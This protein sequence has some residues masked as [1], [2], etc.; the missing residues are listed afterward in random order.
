MTAIGA[1]MRVGDSRNR[2]EVTNPDRADLQLPDMGGHGVAE[3]RPVVG[4][5][6]RRH[7]QQR[8]ARLALHKQLQDNP[9]QVGSAVPA[10]ALADVDRARRRRV[11][12]VVVAVDVEACRR[13]GARR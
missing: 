3:A 12:A 10:V 7:H 2:V 9:V 8:D 1:M 5:A 4:V 6:A 11:A 13:S